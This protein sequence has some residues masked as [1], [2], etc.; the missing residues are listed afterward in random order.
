MKFSANTAVLDPKPSPVLTCAETRALEVRAADVGVPHICDAR[1]G[2]PVSGLELMARA[3]QACFKQAR[4]LAQGRAGYPLILCGPGGN[5]GDGYVIARLFL[6]AD[7]QPV[8]FALG[9]PGARSDAAAMY[10]RLKARGGKVIKTLD[11][12]DIGDISIVVDALFGVGLARA[13]DHPQSLSVLRACRQEGIPVFAVD[14]PSGLSGDTGR[15]SGNCAGA[16]LTLSF[17]TVKPGHLIADGPQYC[18]A[19][20]IEDLDLSF[21]DSPSSVKAV[22]SVRLSGFFAQQGHKYKYG[23]AMVLSG[24]AGRT[25]AARLAAMAALRMGA[26]LVSVGSSAEA[27]AENAAHLTSI[28]LCETGTVR[29]FQTLLA[30][31]RY[32]T[33]V[34]GPGFGVGKATR[35]MVRFAAKSGRRLVLDADALIS[36]ESDP[37][38]LFALLTPECV[39]TP[40]AGEFKRLFPDLDLQHPTISKLDQVK[41]A[42]K[43]SGAV[44]LLK[45]P[46][47]FIAAPGGSVYIVAAVYDRVAP[48]LG[49][50]GSGDVL[51]G[52]IAG[53][54]AR[55]ADMSVPELTAQAVWIH[56]ELGRRL[57]AGLIAEDLPDGLRTLLPG[58]LV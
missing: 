5:G 9:E 46:D 53:R 39:L 28:Q 3:G 54:L 21:A 22:T 13:F 8:V 44:M 41:I 35:E 12:L 29:D 19:L 25:G 24:P 17:F 1:T 4:K 40:H 38:E 18:G 15:V 36:F 55:A 30:D 50:A 51:T 6:D 26:G 49:T 2:K 43:R 7:Q 11:D 56:Q 16:D 37:D 32:N 52:L 33:I 27:M 45:G 47:T 20:V 57:G 14:M 31:T 48:A 42:A 23:H 34:I 58:L 10:K